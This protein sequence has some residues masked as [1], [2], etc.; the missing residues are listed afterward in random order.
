[1][2]GAIAA[3]TALLAALS[4]NVFAVLPSVHP[5]QPNTM[6]IVAAT[7]KAA[8]CK[9]RVSEAP[10]RTTGNS[11]RF[12]SQSAEEELPLRPS[13]GNSLKRSASQRSPV[14]VGRSTT[15]T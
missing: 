10:C 12:H 6:M 9:S 13:H 3:T 7:P 15:A 14:L 2:I 4:A 1:Q 5:P 11:M 8:P